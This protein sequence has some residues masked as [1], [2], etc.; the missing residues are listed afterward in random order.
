[1]S[2]H[3]KWSQIKRQK[4]AADVKRGQMFTK[5]GREIAIAVREGGPDPDGN[6]RL[7]QVIQR[8]R[9]ASMPMDTIDRA[10]KRATGGGEAAALEEISYE[11]YGPGGAAV[12]VEALTDNRNRAVAEIRSAFTRA[13]GS[14]GESGCV[15]WLFEPRGVIAVEN[16]DRDPD[17]LGLIAIDAGAE[18]VRVEDGVVEVLTQPADLD[19]VRAALEAAGVKV[20]SAEAALV[21]KTTVPLDEKNAAA[22]LRLMEKLED[23]DDVQRVYTNLELSEAA[24]Q[25]YQSG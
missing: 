15:A 12:L 10:I 18:D 23:L 25:A 3:S 5:L 7:R 14:L 9:E 17:E 20:A 4:G 6:A 19:A 2:G 1:M 11:G 8:A 13:G 24:L 16:G 21:P 22:T